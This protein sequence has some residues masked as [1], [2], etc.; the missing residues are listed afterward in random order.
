MVLTT[1]MAVTASV[2]AVG[3]LV[4]ARAP[5]ERA[6]AEQRGAHLT[7]QFD[8]AKVT[9]AR[10]AETTDA[11]GVTA[12]AG[13]F[14]TLSVRPRTVTG[15]DFMPAGV[16]LPPLT[17]V[18]RKDPGGP[19]D[20]ID[21][22]EGSWA[23]RPGQIVLAADGIPLRPGAR[24]TVPDAPGAPT[25]TVVGLA[26]S[27]TGTGDA[28][29]TPAQAEALAETSAAGSAGSAE[30]AE[31]TESGNGVGGEGGSASYEML[32]RFRHAATDSEVA[33]GRAA[34]VAAVPAGAMSGARS[35]LTVKQEETANAMAFVPF[36]AAFGV[37]GLCLSVL[38]I[39]IVVG[40]AVGAATRRIGVLKALG[41]T[42]AQVV[43]AYVAQA[44]V[45]AAV[46]CV[47][48]VALGNA[49]AVPVLAEVG[50]A[51]GAPAGGIPVWVDVAVPGAA[52]VLVAGAAVVPALR[53]GRLRT[54]EA[55][56]VG[57]GR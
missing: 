19:V 29:V 4:A 39:G 56:A 48:G 33:V 24:L 18:G 53:A 34:I 23:T 30:S 6:F 37:L 36:L 50:E 20:E 57:G 25:L 27:V 1:L 55:I 15:S 9:A 43:R 13:P 2:L 31:N 54:V 7:G 42:P 28:W 17:V 3:L 22:I 49:L 8:G 5:F 45:P 38:V 21:L 10:L 26:R 12:T 51:F 40:G 16:D 32:Y 11:P 41:F 14:L 35:Y 44:L 47:L 46:G 52:L